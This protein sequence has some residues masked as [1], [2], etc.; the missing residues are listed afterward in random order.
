MKRLL[1]VVVL[2]SVSA[3]AWAVPSLQQV[4][5]EVKAGR[6]TQAETMMS[7]VVADKGNSAKA[8]YVYA[9]VL[10]HNGKFAKAT[11]EARRARQIDPDLKFTT[12]ERFRSFE[13]TLQR[14]E[15]PGARATSTTVAPARAAPVERSSGMPSWILRSR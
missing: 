3:M 9:E 10:A 11:E 14:E 2:A 1:A 12:P 6:Y 5:D 7:E 4:E 8:H 15:N 13:Q